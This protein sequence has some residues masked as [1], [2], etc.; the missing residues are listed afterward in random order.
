MFV[1]FF[2][3]FLLHKRLEFE[4]LFFYYFFFFFNN[5]CAKRTQASGR[6]EL[7]HSHAVNKDY[8]EGGAKNIQQ[9]YV[10]ERKKY[11]NNHISCKR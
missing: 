4:L 9:V 3:F 10:I 7:F 2:F 8:I 11:I 5:S 6:T 1:V